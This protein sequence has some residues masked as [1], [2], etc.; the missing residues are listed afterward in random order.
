MGTWFLSTLAVLALVAGIG[1]AARWLLRRVTRSETGVQQVAQW[2]VAADAQV[3][4]VR[5]LGRVH[6]VYER[7]RESTLLETRDAAEFEL[8]TAQE[9]R[10]ISRVA[11][12]WRGLLAHS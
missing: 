6:I 12:G 4:A 3:R 1:F 11:R 8:A 7:G 5:V 2:R 10:Q 9:P